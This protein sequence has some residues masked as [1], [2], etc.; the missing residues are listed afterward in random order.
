MVSLVAVS[1]VPVKLSR[2]LLISLRLRRDSSRLYR[3]RAATTASSIPASGQEKAADSRA[4]MV[5]QT[6]YSRKLGWSSLFS[7]RFKE[8][9][10]SQ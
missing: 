9:A 4:K 1:T 5:R 8:T 2:Y 6:K 10:P 3:A 7:F